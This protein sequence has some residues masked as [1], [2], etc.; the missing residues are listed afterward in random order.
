MARKS[1]PVTSSS[2]QTVITLERGG[3]RWALPARPAISQIPASVMS[4]IIRRLLAFIALFASD[5]FEHF[6]QGTRVE[7]LFETDRVFLEQPGFLEEF[8]ACVAA[9]FAGAAV[10][11]PDSKFFVTRRDGIDEFRLCFR[12]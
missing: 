6:V 8:N 2:T 3:S 1:C 12:Q 10:D 7:G 9:L 11:V 4:E 5:L